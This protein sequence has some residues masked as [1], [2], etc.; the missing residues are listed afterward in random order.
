MKERKWEGSEG[1]AKGTEHIAGH[2]EDLSLALPG[3]NVR[4]FGFIKD[5][6]SFEIRTARSVR[7]TREIFMASLLLLSR[8]T[9]ISMAVT[10]DVMMRV[11]ASSSTCNA[12]YATQISG[13]T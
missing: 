10:G 4:T 11:D 3:A 5:L 6:I 9:D 1:D 8:E 13:S 2:P 7:F 12:T